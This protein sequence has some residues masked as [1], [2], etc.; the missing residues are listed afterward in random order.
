MPSLRMQAKV[1]EVRIHLGR[2]SE[3]PHWVNRERLG[4]FTPTNENIIK[5]CI[6][7]IT[8]HY[9][10]RHNEEENIIKRKGIK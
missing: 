1:S 2:M 4:K 9:C 8:P 5:D 3:Q 7:L 6:D 10:Y